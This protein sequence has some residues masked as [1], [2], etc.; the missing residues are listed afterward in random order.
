VH[1]PRERTTPPWWLEPPHNYNDVPQ[2]LFH[3]YG[4]GPNSTENIGPTT[5]HARYHPAYEPLFRLFLRLHQY[6]YRTHTDLGH[7]A[8]LIAWSQLHRTFAI[9][10]AEHLDGLTSFVYIAT[11]QRELPRAHPTDAEPSHH[12]PVIPGMQW[13]NGPPLRP[14]S[15][16]HSL[17]ARYLDYDSD[18]E[19]HPS[20]RSLELRCSRGG[21][22]CNHVLDMLA[23]FGWK[24]C[25][26]TD[27]RYRHIDYLPEDDFPLYVY[28]ELPPYDRSGHS[29]ERF[30]VADGTSVLRRQAQTRRPAG[31]PPAPP[32]H[33]RPVAPRQPAR[34]TTTVRSLATRAPDPFHVPHP[35]ALPRQTPVNALPEHLRRRSTPRSIPRT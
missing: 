21:P 22:L 31:Q 8:K 20:M 3:L 12:M 14:G 9:R 27:P 33:A 19:R 5:S 13:W 17:Y 25:P 28:A 2:F 6:R 23:E 4:P 24:K 10:M 11:I 30:R 34:G 16:C 35:L 26:P 32:N 15:A 1:R 29:P 7:P 18:P